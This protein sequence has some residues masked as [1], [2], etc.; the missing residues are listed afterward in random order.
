MSTHDGFPVRLKNGK[1]SEF[2]G[3][4]PLYSFSKMVHVQVVH[5]RDADQGW[6]ERNKQVS[7]MLVQTVQCVQ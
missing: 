2:I 7:S 1:C 4:L 6:A 3:K 5:D